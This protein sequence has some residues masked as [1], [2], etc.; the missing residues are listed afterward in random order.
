MTS[1]ILYGLIGSLF[2]LIGGLILLWRADLAKKA[3]NVLLAFGAGTF[4]GIALLD[5]LPEAV[6]MA[7]EPHDIFLAAA[8]GFAAFFAFERYFMKHMKLG[9]AAHAHSEHVESLPWMLVAGDTGHN[10]LDGVVI[11]LA[12][13]AN[14]ALGLPTAIAVAM[15]EVP[16]EIADFA[17]L[18]D[19][20]WSKAKVITVNVFSA[21]SAFIGIGV[22]YIAL[23]FLESSLP[24][25]LGSVGGIFIYIAASQLV[26][27]IHHRAG[28]AHA[29]RIFIAFAAGIILIWYLISLTR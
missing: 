2:S 28:H 7:D 10:F 3:T 27:E 22:A 19:R 23:P 16:Q 20:G 8:A 4:I 21:L 13:I 9:A 24:I 15:H 5:I 11:A 25:L 14:P 18:L 26:P 1:L 6:E 29:N 17:I 12:Y